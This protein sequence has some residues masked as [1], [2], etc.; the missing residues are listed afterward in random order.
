MH[1]NK[2]EDYTFTIITPTYNSKETIIRCMANLQQNNINFEHII[3]DDCSSDSTISTIQ[4][5]I[6]QNKIDNVKLIRMDKNAGPGPA[7]NI[8]LE[9]AKGKY[10]IFCDADDYLYPYSLDKIKSYLTKNNEPDLCIFGCDLD[11]GINKI[12][13]L[14]RRNGMI[15]DNEVFLKDY[16]LDHVISSPWA[17]VIKNTLINGGNDKVR[18]PHTRGSE[19]SIFNLEIFSRA[20][21]CLYIAESFYYFDKTGESLTRKVFDEEEFQNLL[22]SWRM[23]GQ[24]AKEYFL[25][26]KYKEELVARRLRFVCVNAITRI[27]ISSNGKEYIIPTIV[28]TTIKEVALQNKYFA[29]KDLSG[30]EKVL[31]SMF[32]ISPL[33][34]IFFLNYRN[35]RK[36]Q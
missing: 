30:K 20:G 23:F 22:E 12:N 7:R 8:A 34:A 32:L 1:M 6:E 11:N 24:K 36:R 13:A 18:F 27:S 25:D 9:I 17:K 28:K 19:D 15:L 4:N 29:C 14:P 31:I 2:I 21:S 5:Y 26:A 35:T 33:L 10:V 3:V 16:I